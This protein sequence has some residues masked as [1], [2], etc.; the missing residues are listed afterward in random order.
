MK[1][2]R[3]R[4]DPELAAALALLPMTQGQLR[5]PLFDLSDIAGTRAAIGQMASDTSV[6]AELFDAKRPD[7]AGVSIGLLRPTIRPAPL[8]VLALVSRRLRK[9]PRRGGRNSAAFRC[10]A[11]SAK[12]L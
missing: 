10:P 3:E 5:A 8:P 11:E 1:T 9:V 4:L 6:S 7:G 12:T 2:P